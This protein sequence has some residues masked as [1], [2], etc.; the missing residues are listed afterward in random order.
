MKKHRWLS[1]LMVSIGLTVACGTEEGGMSEGS[2]GSDAGANGVAGGQAGKASPPRG[3]EGGSAGADGSGG[4]TAPDAAGG[5]AGATAVGGSAGS[6]D[7]GGRGGGSGGPAGAGGS[8]NGSGG[9]SGS[10][11]VFEERQGLVAVEAEAFFEIEGRGHPRAWYLTT[12]SSAPGIEPDPDPSHAASASGGAYMEVLPDTRVTH[13]DSLKDALFSS[14]KGAPTLRYKVKFTTTGKYWVWARAFSTG[15]EDNGV[16]VGIDGTWPA[17]GTKMQ[18][19]SGK[20]KWTWSSAQRDSDGP[21]G[22]RN[23]I[24]IEVMTPGE[25]V[26]E[27][28]MREDG[29]EFDK[30]LLTTDA[31]YTPTDAGP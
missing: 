22:K 23:T 14:G 16:H 10:K 25:H 1:I 18:W 4:Q 27:F 30:F 13:D 7:A 28:G 9:Q 29:F 11:D 26:I 8:M 19:C 6:P 31:A 20:N 21:C 24:S 12:T 3:G 2:G 15:S 17:S 5:M